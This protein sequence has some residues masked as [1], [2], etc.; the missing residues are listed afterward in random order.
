[1]RQSV[2]FGA[3]FVE[4]SKAL[5]R[6][7]VMSHTTSLSKSDL[8]RLERLA[9]DAGT[10]PQKIL[11]TVLRDGFEYCGMVRVP[12]QR[13][14]RRPQSRS[15][16]EYRRS[17]FRH[18]KATGFAWHKLVGE[19]DLRVRLDFLAVR[20]RRAGCSTAS[21]A[22]RWTAAARQPDRAVVE[23]PQFV[24]HADCLGWVRGTLRSSGI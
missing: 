4:C 17:A 7:K 18:R 10:T 22:P 23:R 19:R 21:C 12:G 6:G 24:A 13:G 3:F 9:E 20:E 1:M 2:L 5:N 16:D 15:D 11:K 8:R 14:R